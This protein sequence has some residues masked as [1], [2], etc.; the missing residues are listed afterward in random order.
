MSAVR[1]RFRLVLPLLALLLPAGIS[2]QDPAAP[3][4][5][6]ELQSIQQK[7]VPLQERALEDS[8]LRA[9]RDAA[10]QALQ[11]AMVAI[12]PE[13]AGKLARLEAMVEEMRAAQQQGDTAKIGALNGE[14]QQLQPQV[15]Q[16]QAQA[17]AQPEIQQRI[18]LFQQ[19]LHKRM[20]ELDPEADTLLKRA[21]ELEARLRGGA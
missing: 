17:M 6:V 5:V 2:A 14:A 10:T 16:V 20:I 8:T 7:L 15:I 21:A 12:D 19:N 3:D 18:A 13:I 9:E 4:P 1:P 11:A